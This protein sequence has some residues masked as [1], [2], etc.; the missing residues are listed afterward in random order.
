MDL[1]SE[2]RKRMKKPLK[3]EYGTGVVR[4]ICEKNLVKNTRVTL[5]AFTQRSAK[6]WKTSASGNNMT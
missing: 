4:E 6:K 2:A 1:G 5:R 3:K